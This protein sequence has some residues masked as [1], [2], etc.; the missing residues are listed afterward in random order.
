MK[1]YAWSVLASVLACGAAQAVVELGTPFSD[2]MVL[3]RDRSVPVW[4]T[5]DAGEEVTVSFAGQTVKTTAKADGSW[6]LALAPLA[7]S[8]ESREFVVT[9]RPSDRTRPGSRKIV[10]DVLVGEVWFASGQSNMECPIWGPDPHYRDGK[11][12]MMIASTHRPLVRWAKTPLRWS[13]KP[14]PKA[15]IRWLPMTPEG[16]ASAKGAYLSAVAYYYALELYNALEIPVG[17]VD[18]SWGG[19]NSDAW[20]P[21]CGWENRPE[22]ADVAAYPV[23]AD[24]NDTMKVGVIHGPHQQPTA[25]W[26][27]MVSAWAPFANRGFIWY[28]GCHNFS[29]ARRYC[30]KMHAL[31]DGWSKAFENPGMR[32]YF[33]QL[34]P[35][36]IPWFDIQQQQAKFVTEEPNASMAVLCDQ[37]NLRDIHPNDKEIVAKRLA[38]HA[39]KRDYG[40]AGVRDDSPTLKAWRVEGDRF[41]LSFNDAEGWYVY[42]P[43]WNRVPNFEIAGPDGKFVPAVL[44]GVDGNGR[45]HGKDL[46]VKAEGVK[47]PQRLRYLAKSPFTGTLYS[48]AALPLGAFEVDA[49]TNR[50]TRVGAPVKLGEARKIPELAG[51]RTAL[52]L[53]LPVN[54]AFKAK[55]PAD[56]VVKGAFSRV[57]Y[58]LELEQ[59]DGS[60]DWVMTAMDAFSDDPKELGVPC[61]AGAFR[62]QRVKALTVRSNRSNVKAVTNAEGGLIEFWSPNYRQQTALEGV[63]GSAETYDFNDTCERG[64][65]IGYGSMQVHNVAAGETVWA[66]NDFNQGSVSDLGIGTNDASENGDWTFMH[67]ASDYARRRLTV[68][69]K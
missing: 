19:T 45:L 16:F 33:A 14:E 21:R 18:A 61:R 32:L 41:V 35:F 46:V 40:F 2:G 51:Y 59:P 62:Q 55:P 57:A 47:E 23:R 26:N 17:I 1:Q 39:L 25:L 52:Q 67:N 44:Q 30:S 9:G 48:D 66:F 27:G 68:L 10:S 38:L 50:P 54:P 65:V 64:E 58:L 24:W 22:L 53:D 12:A 15:D 63:G 6:R 31:Y 13:A 11:G 4:G 34:A 3:Q 43:N 49:R 42:D 29:E 56:P 69:V 8:K 37:G 7:V 36:S 28:Q 20:T 5:A 60:V